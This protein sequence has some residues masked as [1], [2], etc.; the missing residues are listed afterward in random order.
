MPRPKKE[1]EATPKA[2]E[3]SP[4][5]VDA[6]PAYQKSPGSSIGR[7]GGGESPLTRVDSTSTPGPKK[8]KNVAKSAL[9]PGQDPDLEVKTDIPEELQ[10]VWDDE[11]AALFANLRPQQQDFLLVYLREGNAA[12]AYRQAYN[13]MA[14]E[15]LASVSGSKLVA[16]VG[17]AP[18]LAKFNDYKTEA[19]FTVVQGYREMAKATQPKWV[20]DKDGQWENVGDA[21]DWQAR[22]EAFIGIRKVHGLDQ[23]AEV[24]HSGEIVSKV[25]QVQLPTKKKAE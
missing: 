13:K 20:Q 17:I 25:V 21:P 6:P 7:A 8:A 5:S 19:L 3:V 18:I 4:A 23:P 22:K 1:R 2:P 15:H 16:S 11:I 14:K 9:A 24:K 10:T 12:E